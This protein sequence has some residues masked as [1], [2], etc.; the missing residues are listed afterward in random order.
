M[1]IAAS[2]P[3]ANL[4]RGAGARSAPV[5][6]QR[7][8]ADERRAEV[9][10]AA[11]KAFSVGGLAGTSTE[12]VARIAGI[13]QPYLFRL[14]ASK[15][16]LFLAAVGRSYER[17]EIAFRE[18]ARHPAADAVGIDP[19]L[20]SIARAYGDFLGETPL[21]RLQLH[22]FAA[23]DDPV[24]RT[25]VRRHFAGLVSLVSD[26]SGVPASS[27]RDFFA[28]G[29]FMNVAAAMELTEADVAWQAICEGGPA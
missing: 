25:F 18:A 8:S 6:G 28:Q 2:A 24:V 26:L 17:I 9:I 15:R 22:A 11:V 5:H 14:F 21:L 7:L 29:M 19:V 20:L 13:S 1:T 16:D 10:E 27:L 12:D 23:C 4:G 3:T